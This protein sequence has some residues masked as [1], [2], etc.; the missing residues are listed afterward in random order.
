MT[1]LEKI[2]Q[3]RISTVLAVLFWSLCIK[4]QPDVYEGHINSIDLINWTHTDYGYTDHPLI[5]AEFHKRFIDIALDCAVQTRHNLPG[6]RFTWTVEALDPF[7]KWWQETTPERRKKM[8]EC[9]HRGQIDVNAMPF[10]IHP[11][12]NE[13]EVDKLLSWIPGEVEKQ[14][15]PRIAIQN[16]VN[17]FPRSIANKLNGKGV[18]NIWLGMNGHHPWDKP[19]AFWWEMPNG[20]RTFLWFGVAYWTAYDYFH[21]SRW[22]QNQCEASDLSYRWPREEEFFKSDEKSVREAHQIC[23]KKLKELE[24]K[25]YAYE[26]LPLTFSNQWRCD[27]DGP[28]PG[29]VAFVK[30]WN[31]LGLKPKLNLTTATASIETMKQLAGEKAPVIQGEF[32]DWW[33]FG[34]TAMP[35]ETATARLARYRLQAA[36]S[37]VFSS[38]TKQQRQKTDEIERDICTY[39]EHTF[40]SNKA[41]SDIYGIQNQGSMNEAFRYAYKAYEYAGWLLAQKARSLMNGQAEGIYVINTQAATFSGWCKLEKRSIRV[42]NPKS[43]VDARTGLKIKLYAEQ[44]DVYFWAD[45]VEGESF[46]RYT[47]SMDEP[48]VAPS[49]ESPQ[50]ETNASGWPVSI[51]WK[52][53]KAPLFEG[54]APVLY[55]SKFVKG[56][57]WDGNALPGDYVSVPKEKTRVE[58]TPQTIVFSQKLENQRLVSAERILTVYKNEERVH[59]K[60]SYDRVLHTEREPEVIYAEFPFPNKDRRV[61]TSNGGSEFTPYAD[62]IPNTCKA[63]FI[64]DSWVKLACSDGTRVWASRTSP[65][66]ELGKHTFFLSGDIQEPANS[67]LFQSMLYNNGWSVNFPTE[68]SGKTVSEQDIYW[69]PDNPDMKQIKQVSDAY[70]VKPVIIVHPGAKENSFYHQWMNGCVLNIK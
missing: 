6:E 2:M 62:N 16:D 68:Y 65:V 29:I 54:E 39:Y 28:F 8:V 10:N 4:A 26:M 34:M 27:N 32:G 40:A 66:F 46:I 42:N 55:V 3:K 57:W 64:A 52:S 48:D 13:T 45:K 31:E 18:K 67:Y 20:N 53:M 17:G 11:L 41:G 19:S 69:T 5:V 23:L 60:I 33:A 15:Q 49:P 51:R 30:K 24:N 7:W 63:F 36:R 9:I 43:L 37:P 58:E 21:A 14:V 70:L 44:D 38:L 22:R 35:R 25:G 59:V 50:I 61:T 1:D 56:G 12:L 47:V